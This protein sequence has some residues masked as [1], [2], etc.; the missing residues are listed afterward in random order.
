MGTLTSTISAIITL[1]SMF[2]L[3]IIELY[4]IIL[5]YDLLKQSCV[6]CMIGIWTEQLD[7]EASESWIY[8]LVTNHLDAIVF[9][10]MDCFLLS[11][12]MIL[13]IIQSSQ[14]INLMMNDDVAIS[15]LMIMQACFMYTDRTEYHN[16]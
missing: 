10:A 7:P 3:N 1:E 13:T 12:V 4:L 15:C 6:L 11:G 2:N 5:I 8:H 14:V 16:K 9:L